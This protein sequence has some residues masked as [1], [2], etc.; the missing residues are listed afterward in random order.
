MSKYRD[1]RLSMADR[2]AGLDSSREKTD[3]LEK[4]W[5][6]ARPVAA[7][8]LDRSSKVFIY[9]AAGVA[10]LPPPFDLPAL[11]LAGIG[12]AMDLASDILNPQPLKVTTDFVLDKAA[13][14]LPGGAAAM[15]ATQAIKDIKN[16]TPVGSN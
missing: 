2:A 16:M 1:S 11:P 8:F 13:S 6:T 4:A 10:L 3:A 9:G 15:G 7:D 5:S 12:G 14:R